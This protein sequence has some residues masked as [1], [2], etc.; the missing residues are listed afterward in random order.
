MAHDV[1]PLPGST[2]IC[3]AIHSRLWIFLLVGFLSVSS[4]GQRNPPTSQSSQSLQNRAALV[5]GPRAI[6]VS[7][8]CEAIATLPPPQ[9]H[10]YP[11]HPILAAQWYG[12]LVALAEEAKREHLG[13]DLSS[14][15]LNKLDEENGL[16]AEIIRK[17]AGDIH[18]T[19]SQIEVYYAAHQSEFQRTTLRHILISDA[20]ALGSRSNRSA[21]EA[22][23]RAEQLSAQI[24]AGQGFA[25]LAAKNSDDP[26]T[27][28]K[29]GDLGEVSHHQL[30]PAVDQVLW[31]LK[32][33]Q[34]SPPFQ[35]RFGYEIIKVEGRRTL[36]LKDV[37][38]S[39]TREIKVEGSQRRQ[40][41]II[42]AAHI[43]LTKTFM[44]SP[45]PC[46]STRVTLQPKPPAP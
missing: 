39:I 7:E 25:E 24:Q 32:P 35:G 41:E 26:Y 33:G 10:G 36:P 8:L 18:P 38:A 2:L 29:G 30:E 3:T 17:V 28:E 22:K 11:L 12:P 1:K 27:R 20:A 34:T 6:T 19:D 45:L 44:G 43:H 23:A 13:G 37:R 9:A 42:A 21:V 4:A 40:Q 5:V 46:E 16:A 14:D 15:N 31:S